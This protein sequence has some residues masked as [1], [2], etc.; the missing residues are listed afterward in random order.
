M[1]LQKHRQILKSDK[2]NLQEHEREHTRLQRIGNRT[3]S[4][5]DAY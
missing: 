3:D 2:Y 4:M 5:V 1:K